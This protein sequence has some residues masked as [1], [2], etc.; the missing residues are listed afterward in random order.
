MDEIAN[1]IAKLPVLD[2]RSPAQI[3]DDLNIL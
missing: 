1:E 2:S 3:M